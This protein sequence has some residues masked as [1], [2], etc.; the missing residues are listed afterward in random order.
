MVKIL[1]IVISM[2]MQKEVMALCLRVQFFLAVPVV[3]RY[4]FLTF[5]APF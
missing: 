3:S 2:P 1:I 5:L 4:L